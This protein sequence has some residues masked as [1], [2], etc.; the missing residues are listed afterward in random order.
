LSAAKIGTE[1]YYPVPLHRQECLAGLGYAEQSLPET[2]LAAK[3]LLSLPIFPDR[4]DEEQVA[5]VGQIAQYLR[6]SRSR[7]VPYR[8][9]G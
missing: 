1:I 5:V 9:A 7:S 2:K 6:G 8:A 4:R 3:E